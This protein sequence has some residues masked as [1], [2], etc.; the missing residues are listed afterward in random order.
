MSACVLVMGF[1]LVGGGR[2]LV[3][4]GGVRGSISRRELDAGKHQKEVDR[5]VRV[6]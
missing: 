2:Q 6:L 3:G 5:L 1:W 4:G